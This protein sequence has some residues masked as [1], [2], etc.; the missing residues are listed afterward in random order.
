[1]SDNKPTARELAVKKAHDAGK[2]GT[3]R[4]PRPKSGGVWSLDGDMLTQK[5]FR[6]KDIPSAEAKADKK[7]QLKAAKKPQEAAPQESKKE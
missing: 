5:S 1:M 7:E 2:P 6:G 3:V 4:Y